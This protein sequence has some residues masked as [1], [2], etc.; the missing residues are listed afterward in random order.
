MLKITNF[1][2][3]YN[4]D[5]VLQIDNL[6]IESGINW[7]RGANG[8]GKSTFLKSAAGIIG[9]DGDLLLGSAVSIKEQPV[10]Y[11]KLVNFAEAEPVF[12]EFLTG[13]DL[14][15]L[16]MKAKSAP[17]KQADYFIETMK[18]ESYVGDPVGSFSSG[19]HKKLSLLLA[20]IGNPQL[21]LLDEP[22]ITMDSESLETLYVWITDYHLKLGTDFLLSSH[23]AFDKSLLPGIKALMVADHT[24]KYV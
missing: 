17:V 20:F 4:K 14:I 1:K 23:Q 6:T 2:K 18:M 9:F 10:S 13:T 22:L 15:R 16:F 19:M 11:R 21:I 12:P 5:I 7:V 24:L 3:S 8:S